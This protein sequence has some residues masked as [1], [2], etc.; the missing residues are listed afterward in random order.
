M[1]L[2]VVVA[3]EGMVPAKVECRSCHRQH[4]YRPALP[5]TKKE[6]TKAAPRA[7][8][9]KPAAPAGAAAAIAVPTAPDVNQLEALLAAQS[10]SP[11]RSYSPAERYAVGDILSHSSF[12]LGAVTG[13]PSPGKIAVLFRDT[14][15]LLL[16]ERTPTLSDAPRLQP[17]PRRADTVSNEPSARPPKVK[18]LL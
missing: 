10:T 6:S 5:G 9:A 15:R 18:S 8:R 7:P 13:T 14:T 3:M 16:H 1:R 12:G 2:H 4:K 11:P 17:P